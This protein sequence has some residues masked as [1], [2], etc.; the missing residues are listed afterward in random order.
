MGLQMSNVY[1]LFTD[2]APVEK[3]ACVPSFGA[4]WQAYPRKVAKRAAQRAWQKLSA[5]DRQAALDALSGHVENWKQRHGEDRTYI[6]HPATW[7]NGA[8]WEDEL[9]PVVDEK[10]A[11]RP[12][13]EVWWATDESM[14]RKGIEVGVGRAQPGWSRYEYKARIEA[15]INKQ[16][17]RAA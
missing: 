15:A 13:V 8:R 10:P 17:G 2:M 6:P 4:W 16:S 12:A 1:E 5:A 3:I 9:D 7:L 14:E 11:A